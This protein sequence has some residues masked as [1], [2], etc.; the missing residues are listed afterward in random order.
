[1][2]IKKLVVGKLLKEKLI[3]SG[4]YVTFPMIRT[5]TSIYFYSYDLGI[6]Y[7]K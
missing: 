6:M 2:D 4:N 3:A 7:E 1:M 5:E